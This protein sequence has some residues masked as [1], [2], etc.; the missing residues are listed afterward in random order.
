MSANS[1]SL[2]TILSIPRLRFA[3]PRVRLRRGFARFAPHSEIGA[4]KSNVVGG[5]VVLVVAQGVDRGPELRPARLHRI[6]ERPR[7]TLV[8]PALGAK[9]LRFLEIFLRILR[10]PTF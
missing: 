6:F 10:M 1:S 4:R 8:V 3:P 2:K 7:L 5:R 9:T